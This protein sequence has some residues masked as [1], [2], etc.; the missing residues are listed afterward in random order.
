MAH[1]NPVKPNVPLLVSGLISAII[2]V[3]LPMFVMD[4]GHPDMTFAFCAVAMVLFGLYGIVGV[5]GGL[6]TIVPGI[7]R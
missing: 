1:A 4:W 5:L 6:A 7:S 2:G 3:S